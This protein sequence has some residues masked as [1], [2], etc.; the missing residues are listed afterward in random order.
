MKI[1]VLSACVFGITSLVPSL[2]QSG[3]EDSVRP[4][5]LMVVGGTA[6]N[7]SYTHEKNTNGTVVTADA[8]AELLVQSTSENGFVATWKMKS[9]SV[10][11]LF[12]DETKPEAASLF[13]G[14]PFQY[15][16]GSDGEP[17]R[18]YN[19]E[20]LLNGLSENPVFEQYEPAALEAA[21]DLFNSMT[22]EA[23]AATFIKVPYYM[24]I[25]QATSLPLSQ[26]V[27]TRG[28]VAS[29]FGEGS[30]FGITS[31]E[32]TSV[33]EDLGLA[34]IEYETGYDPE[35][36]KALVVEMFEKVAPDKKPTPEEIEETSIIQSARAEC[37]VDLKTGWVTEMS[38]GS[39]VEAGEEFRSED[40]S[41]SV[42]WVD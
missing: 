13:I 27:E 24:S 22:N 6:A 29:P 21:I 26:E 14:I 28:E 23:L 25:C 42:S 8:T 1:L 32:L 34:Q 16:A 39:I 33:D 19:R 36:M 37:D 18:I 11:D 7:I 35:S 12:V 17:T 3:D 15:A 9:I 2:A 5:P 4:I 20:K 10:G 31:Y 40:Y 38:F 30:L 41:V